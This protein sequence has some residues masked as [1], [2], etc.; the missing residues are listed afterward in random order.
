MGNDIL[1]WLK[2]AIGTPTPVVKGDLP[3]HEFHGNQYIDRD[4]GETIAALRQM[5]QTVAM[6]HTDATKPNGKVLPSAH[7]TMAKKHAEEAARMRQLIASYPSSGIHSFNQ[8][9]DIAKLHER[10]AEAHQKAADELSVENTINA[11]NA[12]YAVITGNNGGVTN[13]RSIFMGR[14]NSDGS[15]LG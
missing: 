15:P 7:S 11:I 6:M 4:A 12:S 10:A 9:E 5:R 2:F 1:S 14:G 13:G 8:E 3:G